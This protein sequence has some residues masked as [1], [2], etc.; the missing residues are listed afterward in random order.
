MSLTRIGRIN[1]SGASSS[2]AVAIDAHTLQLLLIHAARELQILP[3]FALVARGA[4]QIGGMIRDDKRSVEC[5]EAMHPAA[6][7]PERR[8]RCQ[9]V[10]RGDAPDRQHDLWLQQRNLSNQVWQTGSDFLGL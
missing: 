5:P 1:S 4:Q 3:G 2:G 9:Q 7:P 6:Q 10:L 8:S